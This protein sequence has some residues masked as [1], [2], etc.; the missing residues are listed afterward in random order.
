M[1]GF[2]WGMIVGAIFGWLLAHDSVSN[3]C[4]RLRSFYVGEKVY[5]CVKVEVWDG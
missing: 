4:Q 2:M 1:S 3:E 5:H